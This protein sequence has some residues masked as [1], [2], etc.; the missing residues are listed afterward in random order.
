MRLLEKIHTVILSI[1][2][3]SHVFL[4]KSKNQK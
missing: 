2:E 3:E 1:S 4:F